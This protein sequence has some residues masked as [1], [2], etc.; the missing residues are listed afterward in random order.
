MGETF[1]RLSITL[2][3]A[4][5]FSGVTDSRRFWLSFFKASY[6]L[7]LKFDFINR[8]FGL[9]ILQMYVP[10]F[11]FS[12]FGVNFPHG[13]KNSFYGNMISLFTCLKI[14][15][16]CILLWTCFVFPPKCYLLETYIFLLKFL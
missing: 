5:C 4:Q 2:K 7:S 16:I 13:M 10:I 8:F 1:V 11:F 9:S 6:S 3:N 12:K 15:S 14:S